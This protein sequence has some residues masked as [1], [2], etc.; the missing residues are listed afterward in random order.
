M[1][2][3]N[4]KPFEHWDAALHDPDLLDAILDRL[5][6][7]GRIVPSRESVHAHAPLD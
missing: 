7:H 3:T 6:Q 5:L 4:N 2:F 1:I